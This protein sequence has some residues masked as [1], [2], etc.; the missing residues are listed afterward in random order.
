MARESTLRRTLLVLAAAVAFAGCG[1]EET[2]P[3]APATTKDGTTTTKESTT[4]AERGFVPIQEVSALANIFAAGQKDPYN[5]ATGGGG[6]GEVPP[7]WHL[8]KGA[9]II[10]FPR[11]TGK[12]T[13][14]EGIAFEHGPE[15]GKWDKTDSQP[16]G[17]I[18]GIVHRRKFLFLTGVFLT[19]ARPS[20]P[21]PPRLNFTQ[22]DQFDVLAPRIGQTFYVGDGEGRRYR[23]PRGATRL[24]LG[25]VD[26][27]CLVG[28]RMCAP[29]WYNNNAGALEVTVQ[30]ST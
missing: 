19:A 7:V 29:G 28:S 30:V 18:S 13:P 22:D 3:A 1:D 12:I 11:I 20:E 17:G 23:V 6:A 14:V 10:T 2:Q 16:L 5:S 24:A 25:F 4:T 9:R 8:P 21:A 15:G 26:H 27:R